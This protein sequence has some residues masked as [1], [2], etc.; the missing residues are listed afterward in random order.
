MR[1]TGFSLVSALFFQPLWLGVPPQQKRAWQFV[2]S[3]FHV[4]SLHLMTFSV[5]I[6]EHPFHFFNCNKDIRKVT[7]HLSLPFTAKAPVSISNIAATC[8]VREWENCIEFESKMLK[9]KYL[10]RIQE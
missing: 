3:G 2:N 5:P 1:G 9:L 4:I 8:K 10:H 6:H 7:L